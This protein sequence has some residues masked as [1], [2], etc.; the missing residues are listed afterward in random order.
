MSEQ[1]NKQAPESSSERTQPSGSASTGRKVHV[2]SDYRILSAFASREI[3]QPLEEC[4]QQVGYRLN[5][6]ADGREAL[7]KVR[8]ELPDMV[9]LDI[10]LPLMNGFEVVKNL[11]AEPVT[12]VIPV[13]FLQT[14]GPTPDE[15][16]FRYFQSGADCFRS[17]P[18]S[19]MD[20]VTTIRRIF[21]SID[22][23]YIRAQQAS[24][25]PLGRVEAPEPP[26]PLRGTSREH[27]APRPFE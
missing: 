27:P 1:S 4:L 17:A 26:Q 6:A 18:F 3:V 19:L 23:D 5:T 2:P 15:I 12:G 11:K 14:N 24:E 10:D 21:E 8:A 20:V 25:P 9:L 16:V 7:E 13:G 22:P